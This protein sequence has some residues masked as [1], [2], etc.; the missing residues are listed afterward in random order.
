MSLFLIFAGV[1][2]CMNTLL[3][4]LIEL[5]GG[6]AMAS[7]FVAF[8]SS[9]FGTAFVSRMVSRF[10]PTT[11]TDSVTKYNLVGCTGISTLPCDSNGGI[12]QIRNKSG[13]LYQI[14][15]KSDQPIPKGAQVLTIEYHESSDS[16]TVVV[17]PTVG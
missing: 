12:A 14:Q 7:V 13:D 17:D 15:C 5:W 6:F 1:G 16:F 9:F 3:G 2:I 11:E 8:V 4:K 10:M